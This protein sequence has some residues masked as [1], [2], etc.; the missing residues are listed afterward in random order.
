MEF[1][2]T[3]ISVY[4]YLLVML[5]L[6]LI[7]FIGIS[8]IGVFLRDAFLSIAF[9]IFIVFFVIVFYDFLYKALPL[10]ILIL[11]DRIELK[12]KKKTIYW[13]EIVWFSHAAS[14]QNY[15]DYISIKLKNGERVNITFFQKNKN[16]PEWDKFIKCFFTH[17]KEKCPDIKSYY[18][19]KAWNIVIYL[20]YV[21]NIFVPVVLILLKAKILN[22]MATEFMLLSLSFQ[23]ISRIRNNR[24]TTKQ[25]KTYKEIQEEKKM[26]Q[27]LPGTWIE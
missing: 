14:G 7:L 23:V 22:F 6:L 8:L 16:H 11:E 18:D 3:T 4:R 9:L 2:I 21:L 1:K 19:L 20:F 12:E 24:S 25:H 5:V 27:Q 26:K 10:N 17:L 15:M 13:D